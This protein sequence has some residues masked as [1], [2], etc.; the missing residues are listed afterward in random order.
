[1]QVLLKYG[2]ETGQNVKDLKHD[3]DALG[4]DIVRML[5][6]ASRLQAAVDSEKSDNGDIK[7]DLSLLCQVFIH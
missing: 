1:M 6:S 3:F 4:I 2:E 5:D 7:I